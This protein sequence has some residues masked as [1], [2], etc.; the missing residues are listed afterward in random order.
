MIDPDGY[1]PNVG[2]VLMR[3]DGQVFWARRVRR[4]GWQFPQGGMNSDETPVEAMYR[5][6]QEE[7]GLLPEHV[8]VLGCTP[9][10][11]RYRLPPRAIR[12]NERQ[13]CIGQKQ[14]WFLL[15]LTGDESNVRL[16]QNETPEFDNWRWVDFWYPVEH[17][18]MFKRGVYARALRHLA[19][20]AGHVASA[21]IGA[22]PAAAAQAWLPGSSGGDERPRKRSR[23]R[24]YWPKKVKT[25]VGPG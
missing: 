25:E 2:I 11:L 3:A 20:I 14:V 17:V 8:E 16:D 18:V 7:T 15:R 6:L 1:R 10:W 21:D 24:G 13:V 22:M 23:K 5:E 19:P 12:R 4:D 9:G